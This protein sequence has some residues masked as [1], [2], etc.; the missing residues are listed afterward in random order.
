MIVLL[1]VIAKMNPSSDTEFSR[2]SHI[3]YVDN[4]GSALSKG[5]ISYLA[6]K[7]EMSDFNGKSESEILDI[8]FFG[9]S[10]YH[11]T[12]DK[13]FAEAVVK[14][15]DSKIT[16][17]TDYELSGVVYGI[18]SSINN[19]I[20]TYRDYK[21]L[22]LS[23]ED[24]AA[25]AAEL[26]SEDTAVKIVTEDKSAKTSGDDLILTQ[27]NQFFCYLALGFL[28]L[29]VGHTIIANNDANVGKRID[30][31]PVRR[32][33]ISF[34]NT[35]GLITSGIVIW[36]VFILINVIFGM[37]SQVFTEYWWVIIINSFLSMLMA[38]AITSVITSFNVNSQSLSM[39]TNIVSLSMSFMC[40][41][42]VPQWLLGEGVLKVARFLPF[43]WPVYANNMTYASSNVKFDMD[44]LLVCFGMQ[45]LFAA[46]LALAAAFIK[47][48]RLNRV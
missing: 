37:K 8:V 19:Y 41:V 36:L 5:L 27:I 16:Y 2:M 10:E 12:I 3:S 25:K 9:I 15:D 31:S 14:G 45:I 30:A 46:V 43:Y 7:N 20:N 18:N 42:F 38:C 35:A 22:G 11:M 33:K 26:L 39:V 47:N 40:G 4:D 32:K 13:G 34:A 48:S 6:Q 29:G 17:N 44:Q 23:D 24:A 28:A 1:V 21:I